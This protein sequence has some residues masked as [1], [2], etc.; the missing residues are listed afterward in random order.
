MPTYTFQEL[1]AHYPAFLL[2]LFQT[3][4]HV[5]T[6]ILY[7]HQDPYIAEIVIRSELPISRVNNQ[8]ESFT[9]SVFIQSD[10]SLYLKGADYFDEV[11][12]WLRKLHQTT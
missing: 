2:T 3:W 9:S 4:K 5:K 7:K 11:K 12:T 1:E 10:G 6:A 8:T